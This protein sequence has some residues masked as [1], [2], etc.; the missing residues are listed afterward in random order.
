[1]F[2]THNNTWIERM[3]PTHSYCTLELNECN[4]IIS[5][6]WSFIPDNSTAK[7]T[8]I[9]KMIFSPFDIQGLVSN[10]QYN[11]GQF[12]FLGLINSRKKYFLIV[13]II[14]SEEVV[15]HSHIV[16][17]LQP[18]LVLLT[19]EPKQF[20]E[21]TNIRLS[22]SLTC[23]TSSSLSWSSWRKNLNSSEKLQT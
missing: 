20:G 5:F 14:L 12:F 1:M 4:F 7:K 22:S 3:F 13:L 2:L 10:V 8:I 15:S 19:E 17:Q 9:L 23:L 6:I 16:D 11:E 18:L 21:T